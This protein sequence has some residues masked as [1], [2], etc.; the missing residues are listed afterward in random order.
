MALVLFLHLLGASIWVG[1]HLILAIRFV[2][3][4][5]RLRDASELLTFEHKYEPLGMTALG[6]QIATGLHLAWAYSS[7]MAQWFDPHAAPIHII[8][9]KLMTL[10][11]TALIA[12]HARFRVIPKLQQQP[13]GAWVK[14]FC[15]HVL[16]V[17]IL[18]IVFV[19]LGV[20]F[21]F[22]GV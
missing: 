14:V 21:R 18:A 11:L 5:W 16:S 10:L 4:A 12:A 9:Y 13:Q 2:P 3:K 8:G 15:A 19:Y 17:T 22:G 20:V 6:V 1:G 7:D